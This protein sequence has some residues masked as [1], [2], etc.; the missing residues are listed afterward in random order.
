MWVSFGFFG[1]LWYNGNETLNEREKMKTPKVYTENLKKGIVTET[2]LGEVLYSYNKRAK[3]WRDNKRTY[4]HLWCEHAD[5]WY[6]N[7][8]ANEKKYYDHKDELLSIISPTCKHME[9]LRCGKV[10][11]YLFYEVGGFSFHHPIEKKD[12]DGK[13]ANLEMVKIGQ[14]NTHGKS[15]DELLSTAFCDKVRVAL[16]KGEARIAA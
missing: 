7:A 5:S 2:M 11:Y 6:K 3:N 1:N 10:Q 8:E 12:A 15:I 4:S 16:T 9:K 13:Y 14:L